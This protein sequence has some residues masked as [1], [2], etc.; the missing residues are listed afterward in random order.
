EEN[1]SSSA[2]IPSVALVS[3]L[4]PAHPPVNWD[5]G[6]EGFVHV[7]GGPIENVEFY[8]FISKNYFKAFGIRLIE[9]RVFDDRDGRETPKVAIVNQTMARTF[10]GNQ[11]AIGRRIRPENEEGWFTV[12]G[13]VADVKNAGAE[14][15]TGSELYLSLNQI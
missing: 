1:L 10:W 9:G 4:P 11:S 14:S 13:V 12:I 6:I 8:Q 5:T 15:P 3:G 7:P 2:D